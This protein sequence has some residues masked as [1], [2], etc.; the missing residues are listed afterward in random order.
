MAAEGLVAIV[1]LTIAAL[2]C[3]CARDFDGLFGAGKVTEGKGAGEATTCASPAAACSPKSGCSEG[4]CTY[5]CGGCGCECP[6]FECPTRESTSCAATCAVDTTCDVT[7]EL[8]SCLLTCEEGASCLLRCKEKGGS[9]DVDC[10]EGA[11]TQCGDGVI[12]CGR[13]CPK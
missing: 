13:G 7:C 6:K 5:A 2:A 8:P 10:R 12:A 4:A 3:G 11:A 9:C 1:A